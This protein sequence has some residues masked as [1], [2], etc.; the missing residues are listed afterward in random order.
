MPRRIPSKKTLHRPATEADKQSAWYVDL[1]DDRPTFGRRI[2]V[3]EWIPLVKS[4]VAKR[5][6]GVRILNSPSVFGD[7]IV[8]GSPEWKT[9]LLR[10]AMGLQ[11]RLFWEP[12]DSV[13]LTEEG[14][15]R[16]GGGLVPDSERRARQ[17]AS[18]S[19]RAGK[20][21]LAARS[22]NGPNLFE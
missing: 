13:G 6:D 20:R 10:Y 19:R 7:V 2:S 9:W 15:R 3:E 1:P 5:D 16:Y 22:T 11:R 8:V 21:G 14:A 12:L 17:A 18:A 4:L